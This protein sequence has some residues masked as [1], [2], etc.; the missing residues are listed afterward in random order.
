MAVDNIN[1]IIGIEEEMVV[2]NGRAI[3][4]FVFSFYALDDDDNEIAFSF[5]N[6][7]GLYLFVNNE[8]GGYLIRQWTNT[9]GLS[10]NSNNIVW[11]A[12]ESGMTFDEQGSYYYELG[13]LRGGVYET[14]LRFGKFR[15]I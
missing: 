4:D 10:R 13:Y 3:I 6:E 9:T 7:N 2:Y 8:R 15:V 1:T 11:N 5:P 12:S 14:P